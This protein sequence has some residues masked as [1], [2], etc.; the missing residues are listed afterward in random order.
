M[1][2]Q[3]KKSSSNYFNKL[4]LNQDCLLTSAFEAVQGRWTTQVLICVSMGRNRFGLIKEQLPGITDNVLGLRLNHLIDNKLLVKELNGM[5]R[6]YILHEN[7]VALI[8]I[9][10][11]LARW[12][13]QRQGSDSSVSNCVR[14]P[15]RK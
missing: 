3:I 11:N 15:K 14:L 1:A 13:E 4:F 7:G 9:L 12:Q 2:Y 8:E 6:T 10:E 5:E